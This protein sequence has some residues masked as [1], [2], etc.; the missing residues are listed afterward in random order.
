MLLDDDVGPVSYEVLRDFQND[1]FDIYKEKELRGLSQNNQLNPLRFTGLRPLWSEAYV[2][3]LDSELEVIE[4][5]LSAD[6]I[7]IIFP[8]YLSVEELQYYQRRSYYVSLVRER[9]PKTKYTKEFFLC[10]VPRGETLQKGLPTNYHLLNFPKDF[11]GDLV[12]YDMRLKPFYRY[13]VGGGIYQA[14]ISSY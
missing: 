10:Y 13:S 14:T 6:E 8:Q 12:L 4:V 2:N 7:Q 5:P 9:N 11:K 3:K 1:F